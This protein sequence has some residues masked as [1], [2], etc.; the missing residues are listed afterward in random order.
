MSSATSS[1]QFTLARHP[2]GGFVVFPRTAPA[3]R[4]VAGIS[5]RVAS[6]GMDD[7]VEL[8]DAQAH[9]L[10]GAEVMKGERPD[11]FRDFS[12]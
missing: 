9:A 1:G 10:Q 7:P 4:P 12:F 8:W 3:L 11:I 2:H 6:F 5:K